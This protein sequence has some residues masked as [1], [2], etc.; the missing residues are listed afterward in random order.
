MDR[1]LI[2]EPTW[3]RLVHMKLSKE[4]YY[5]LIVRYN[6]EDF[7]GNFVPKRRV[8]KWIYGALVGKITKPQLDL[9]RMREVNDADMFQSTTILYHPESIAEVQLAAISLINY[10]FLFNERE[11]PERYIKTSMKSIQ[12]S[13]L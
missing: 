8:K 11:T 6:D 5:D 2:L 3:N 12:R 13:T 4:R 10:F 1:G 7:D 9:A